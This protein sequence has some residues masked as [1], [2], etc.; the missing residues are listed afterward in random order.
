MSWL[1]FLLLHPLRLTKKPYSGK[2][3][4]LKLSF[5]LFFYSFLSKQLEIILTM[6]DTSIYELDQGRYFTKPRYLASFRIRTIIRL[7]MVLS[8]SSA[9]FFNSLWSCSVSLIPRWWSLGAVPSVF[10]FLAMI[11]P[12]AQT[13]EN[14]D[15]YSTNVL[16]ITNILH[17]KSCLFNSA[18]MYRCK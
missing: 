1:P 15:S 11:Y 8:S 5:L 6:K 14:I 10:V 18:L 4:G 13:I 17:E 9:I 7:L 2:T 12:L 3:M 16:R